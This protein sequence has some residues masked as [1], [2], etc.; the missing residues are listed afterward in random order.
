MK[1][2]IIASSALVTLAPA[3]PA[4][5][6]QPSYEEPAR[7]W[8]SIDDAKPSPEECRQKIQHIREQTGKPKLEREPA[9]PD[10]PVLMYAVDRKIDDCSVI[11]PVSDPS[12]FKQAPE[13]GPP[14]LLPAHPDK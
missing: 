13:P 6:D 14:Q 11:V 1:V 4:T 9:S 7:P 10:K 12:D 3:P 8:K 5:L 2:L